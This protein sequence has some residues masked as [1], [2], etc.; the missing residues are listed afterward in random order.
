MILRKSAHQISFLHIY[1]HSSITFVT[2]FCLTY[3][4]TGDL[5]L[6]VLLNSSVH[7]IMYGYYLITGLKIK[8]PII[9]KKTITTLQLIQFVLIGAQSIIGYKMDCGLPTWINYLMVGYMATMLIL[10]GRFFIKT[11]ILKPKAK[12]E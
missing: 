4:V 7:V 9:V 1:H 8:L 3:E 6:P 12:K 5:Y 2:L 10:F 11:Y